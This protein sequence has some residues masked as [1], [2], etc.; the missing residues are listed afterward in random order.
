MNDE[1]ITMESRILRY[2][3][4]V[5]DQWHVLPATA[6][7]VL[8]VDCRHAHF[9]ELWARDDMG[10]TVRAFR[11]YGTGQPFPPDARYEGTAIGPG[12]YLVWHLL[13]VDATPTTD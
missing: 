13:S 8:H 1:G 7:T 5:D 10:T 9:V 2:E 3:V 12:G 4:P 11:V 6:P